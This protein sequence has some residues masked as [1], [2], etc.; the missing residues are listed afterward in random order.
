MK[1]IGRH[2]R[3]GIYNYSFLEEKNVASNLPPFQ[4]KGKL[5]D[6]EMGKTR[7]MLS[8]WID[9]ESKIHRIES[10]HL[11]DHLIKLK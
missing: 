4:H 3:Q 9:A 2:G 5:S 11:F 6:T 10:F 7:Q 8:M 1:H